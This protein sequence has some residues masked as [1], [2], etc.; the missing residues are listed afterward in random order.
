MPFTILPILTYSSENWT[1]DRPDETKLETPEMRFLR[2]GAGHT[3]LD[4]K[5][6]IDTHVRSGI[7]I[8]NLTERIKGKIVLVLN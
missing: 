1:I 8:L 6:N 5:R 4:Q 2:P 3:V 7:K